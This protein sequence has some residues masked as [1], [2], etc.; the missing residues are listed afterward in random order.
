[1]NAH[2]AV[3]PP[4]FT[5]LMA[6]SPVGCD[7]SDTED[8][9]DTESTGG[10]D[11]PLDSDTSSSGEESDTSD[12]SDTSDD[13][14]GEDDGANEHP[15]DVADILEL[16]GDA[17]TGEAN[18]GSSCGIGSCH[19]PMGNDGT[20]PSLVTAVP[21]HSDVELARTIRFGEGDMPAISTFT[22]QDIADVMAY[23]RK[24]FP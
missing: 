20:A 22:A 8:T 2:K 21:A 13:S 15:E 11:A 5:L 7:S 1:M 9:G 10:M 4:L 3:F 12:V 19:G 17:E 24:S 16:L 6:L 23:L 18:Y 14:T